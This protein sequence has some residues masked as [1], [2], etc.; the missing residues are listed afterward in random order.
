[1]AAVYLKDRYPH[2]KSVA[3]VGT[4]SLVKEVEKAGVKVLHID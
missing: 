3:V 2:V 1:M 4:R